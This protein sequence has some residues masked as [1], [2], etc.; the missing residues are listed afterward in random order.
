[1][2]LKSV[3]AV[4]LLIGL[5]LVA[6]EI[7]EASKPERVGVSRER[8]SRIHDVIE[9]H[10]DAREISGAVTFVA[11]KGRV[12]NYEAHGL[13]DLESK[14]PMAKDSIFRIWSMSKVV[15]GVGILMLMEEGKV[16]LNDLVSRF[17][18]EF[19]NI[20]ITVI[21][22]APGNRTRA[23]AGGP[24]A[25]AVEFYTM[26]SVREVTIQ[27]LLTHTSGLGSGPASSSQIRKIERKPGESLADYIPKLGATPLDFQPGSRWSYSA[28]AGFDTLAYVIQVASGMPTDQFLKQRIFD[29]LGM[30]DTFFSPSQDR[31][32]RVATSYHRTPDGLQKVENPNRMVST[33]YFGLGGG[34]MS[35]AQDYAQFAEML[36]EGGQLNGKRLLSPKTVELMSSAF[37]PDTLPGRAPGIGWGLS[38]QVVT[39]P[40]AA[41]CRVSPGS[42]G[43]D[44]AYGTHFWVDPK[45]KVIGVM[46]I[47]TDN[48]LRQLDR[49]FENAVMQSIVD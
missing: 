7:P 10:M 11:R 16:R 28:A 42:F 13:M 36:V 47:Q 12:I 38:V 40:I 21:Q 37:I 18:P 41:G 6:A 32:P 9:R 30:P 8:V 24:Q 45:E 44:G 27:D 4:S 2:S 31:W 34:L 33:T 25:P 14:R 3:I 23:A 22:D 20:K 39:N 1:M 26:P 48:S 35:T 29:P 17:I 46:M 15:G 49:D 5:P 43:W 19:K